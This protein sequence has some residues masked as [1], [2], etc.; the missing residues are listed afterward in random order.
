MDDTREYQVNL[1]RVDFRVSG[2]EA[3]INVGVY[4]FPRQKCSAC[5]ARR[6]VFAVVAGLV[7]GPKVCG[8]CA[9]IR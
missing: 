8:K 2:L 6:I 9:R 1:T 5:G 3:D 4:R 7:M